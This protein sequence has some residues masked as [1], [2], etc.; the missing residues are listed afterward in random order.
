[1]IVAYRVEV[2]PAVDRALAKSPPQARDRILRRIEALAE[3]PRPPGCAK[4]TGL[5]DTYRVRVG[6]YRILYEVHDRLVLVV[7]VRIGHRRDVYR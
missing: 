5:K 6:D 3:D 7:V 4:L 2:E 1:M